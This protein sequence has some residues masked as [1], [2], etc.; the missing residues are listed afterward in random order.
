[1]SNAY[2]SYVSQNK[3]NETGKVSDT[4]EAAS[5]KETNK[6]GKTVGEPKLSD[7]AAKYYERLKKKYGN[8]DFVLVSEDQKATAQANAS[9]YA[10][11]QK[12]VVLIDEAKIE[13]MATDEKFRKQYEG[14]LSGAKT[15]LEQMKSSMEK[16]GA[17]VAGYGMQV[18][19]GGTTSFFAVL[20]KS[21]SDQKARIEKTAEKKKAEKHTAEKKAQKKAQEERIKKSSANKTEQNENIDDEDAV[22]I[23]ANSIEELMQKIN[24]FTMAERSDNVQTESEMQVGQNFDFKG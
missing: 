24:D 19:D 2:N 13:K 18:N 12:T 1:M 22:T 10:N 8:Y 15:Q 23:T 21:S 16:S 5:A 20:K 17:N 3:S 4:K 7:K 14:I 6:Y 11:A 9:K